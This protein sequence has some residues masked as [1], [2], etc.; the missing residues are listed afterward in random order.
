[1]ILKFEGRGEALF[2]ADMEGFSE[3]H[4]NATLATGLTRTAVEG[5]TAA[6]AEL[7]RVIDK[8]TPYTQ[9]QLRH[10]M[11]TAE[12]LV[13][14]VGFDI[15]AITDIRGSVQRYSSAGQGNTPASAYLT[16]QVE[17]GGRNTKRF[18]LALQAAGAMPKGWR[19]VPAT[20]SNSAARL[21]AFGNV[22][23]GQIQQIVAQVGTELLS[24]YNNRTV[25]PHDKRKGAQAKR[26][27]ALG[28]AGGQ[29]VAVVQRKGRLA[30]GIYLAEARDFGAKLGLGRTGKLRPVFLFVKSV[31]Y[32]VRFEFNRVVGEVVERRLV[33]NVEQ[34][35]QEQRARLQARGNGGA[36]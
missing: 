11:A 6:K 3:R 13:A 27:R 31:S 2:R 5:K 24:G 26:R 36:A 21:D 17:G 16:P 18:E 25:G 28:R 9:G 32:A 22:S 1:M 34:A 7:M 20:G 8:P 10:T 4:I 29:Y 30:P 23:R 35:I 19:A 33:A 15:E 12:Q 14:E